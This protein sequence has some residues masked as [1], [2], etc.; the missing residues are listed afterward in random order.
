MTNHL[1]SAP[2]AV[3]NEA[4]FSG[5]SFSRSNFVIDDR[6][7]TNIA[8]K[9]IIDRHTRSVSYYGRNNK[10]YTKLCT[11]A[12]KDVFISN[13]KQ[14]YLP[15]QEVHLGILNQNYEIGGIENA[16]KILSTTTMT[17]CKICNR[18]IYDGGV[19]CNSCGALVHGPRLLDSH[20]FKCKSCGK[21]ICRSCT[22]DLGI[23]KKVCK[24]C[25]QKSGQP[26]KLISKGM[27]QRVMAISGFMGVGLLSFA[28]K[29][30]FIVGVA[31][32]LI[33][34]GIFAFDY[35]ANP[36]TYELI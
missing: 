7:L 31:L 30:N 29:I 24:E 13:I 12:D 23:F 26:I 35:H 25:A 22:Y 28:M 2:L 34:I 15:F 16:E 8:K 9:F 36:P 32:I 18:Y 14:V 33:G 6:S 17:N 3:Y 21:T 10:R 4:D 11:P 27:N 20:G 19:V 1:S 5:F